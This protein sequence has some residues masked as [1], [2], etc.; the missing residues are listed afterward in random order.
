M[1]TD[2]QIRQ[3]NVELNE[4]LRGTSLKCGHCGHEGTDVHKYREYVGGTGFVWVPQCDNALECWRRW[5]KDNGLQP[6]GAGR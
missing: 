1:V 2:R 3:L 6:V 5:D 4:E